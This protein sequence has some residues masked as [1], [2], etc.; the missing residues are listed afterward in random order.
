MKPNRTTARN[1][2]SDKPIRFQLEQLESRW[3]LAC[4]SSFDLATSTLSITC[5]GS[6]DV[7]TVRDDGAGGI[8]GDMNGLNIIG[9]EGASV[10]NVVINT[11]R[12]HDRVSYELQG[13]LITARDISI[14]LDKGNDQADL[15]FCVGACDGSAGAP[16]SIRA[17]L[18]VDV[19]AGDGNDR[20]AAQ[21]DEFIGGEGG[22]NGRFSS[23]LGRGIDM[24]DVELLGD[25]VSA[26]VQVIGSGE[27]GADRLS[28]EAVSDLVHGDGTGIDVD[29]NSSLSMDLSGGGEFDRIDANYRGIYDAGGGPRG[30]IQ[31]PDGSL[32]ILTDGGIG[33]DIVGVSAQFDDGSDGSANLDVN[34]SAGLDRLTLIAVNSSKSKSGP[35]IDASLDGGLGRDR[36]MVT[37]QVVASPGTEVVIVIQP[38]V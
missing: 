9:A 16:A 4:S 10:D 31:P 25:L 32:S 1:S 12:G 34:G 18:S 21:F 5:N 19:Q 2:G 14:I 24:L 23:L 7:I 17:D 28:V 38:V 29:I 6:N 15:D 3:L 35:F 37:S 27:T 8:T 26:S 22:I 36:A 20:V 33:D 11:G 30:S 13:N